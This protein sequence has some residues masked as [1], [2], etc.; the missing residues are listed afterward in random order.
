[1]KNA[2]VYEGPSAI[3]GA[4]IVAILTGI[5]GGSQNVKT[6]FNRKADGVQRNMVQLFIIRADVGPLEAI[7]SGD[8]ASICGSCVHR[9]RWNPDTEKFERSC[10][11]NVGQSVQVIYRTFLRGAYARVACED[12][13]MMPATRFGAYGDPAALPIA[14]LES[15]SRKADGWTGYTHLWKT[16]N[17]EMKRFLMASVDTQDE[18]CAARAAG[19]RTF[20][21]VATTAVRPTAGAIWCPASAAGGHRA[22][23]IDCKL[24]SGNASGG[25]SIEIPAHGTDAAAVDNRL[26]TIA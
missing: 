23:C 25:K 6:G 26:L 21:V 2:I 17:P 22:R 18:T 15:L 14:V 8:D 4:P 5:D 24:C 19:W 9:R 7:R 3:D 13:P 16:C 20:G 10:Y 1:M 11:V 12:L